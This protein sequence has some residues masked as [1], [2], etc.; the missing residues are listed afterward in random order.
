MYYNLVVSCSNGGATVTS[1]TVTVTVNPT[2]VVAITPASGS[3][4]CDGALVDVAASVTNM[5]GT[6]TYAWTATTASTTGVPGGN[7]IRTN[8]AAQMITVKPTNATVNGGTPSTTPGNPTYSVIVTSA[9]GCA[10]LATTATYTIVTATMPQTLTLS[11]TPTSVC[12][13]GTPV[14]FTVNN[15][16]IIGAGTWNYNWFQAE[17][18]TIGW[19]NANDKWF[20]DY[21]KGTIEYTAWENGIKYLLD[22]INHDH[23]MPLDGVELER[24]KPIY[25]NSYYIGYLDNAQ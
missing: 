3:N 12:Q 2:P 1:N 9:A 17:K 21:F 7:W 18:G 16:G 6:F 13:P 11:T 20:F 19:T 8:P 24:F 23:M 10:S 15:A 5:T 22:N 4:V 25:S 14:T